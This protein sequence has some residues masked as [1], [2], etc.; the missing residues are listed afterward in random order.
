MK[1][2]STRLLDSLTKDNLWIYILYLLVKKEMYPYEIRR[3]ITK[4]FGF[5][6]GTV[7]AYVVLYKLE[8][9][10]YVRYG[11]TKKISGPERKYYK[12]TIKGRNELKNGKRIFRDML[13][14]KMI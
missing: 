1:E 11:E 2:P 13:K 3:E 4:V 5:N 12:I 8:K 10:G 9:D 7:T 6:P 14:N